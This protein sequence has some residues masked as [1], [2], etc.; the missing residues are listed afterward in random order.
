MKNTIKPSCLYQ[1]SL[2]RSLIGFA[3][4]SGLFATLGS[5]LIAQYFALSIVTSAG[6]S[7]LFLGIY[8]KLFI[9]T[10]KKVINS[11]NRNHAHLDAIL[12]EDYNQLVKPSYQAGSIHQLQQSLISL[13]EELFKKKS[14]YD[15]H[16]FLVYQ[17]IE[18]FNVPIMVLD[19]H[20]K[21]NYANNAFSEFKQTQWQT[22]RY[23]SAEQLGLTKQDAHWQFSDVITAQQWQIRHSE[24]IEQGS[25]HQLIVMIDITSALRENQLQAWQQIIRVLGHEIRNSLTPVTAMAENLA[26]KLTEPRQVQA[27]NVI[28]ERCNYLNEFVTRYGDINKP[29]ALNIV[30]IDTA[31]FLKQVSAIYPDTE[32]SCI[33]NATTFKADRTFIHQ[34]MI[35][36]IKNAIEAS[37]PPVKIALSIHQQGRVNCITVDDNGQGL[38]NPDNIFVPFY[39]TKQH[40]QGIGLSFCRNVIEQ[41]HGSL[42]LANKEKHL[43]VIA[44]I[45]LPV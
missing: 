26:V 13:S 23:S 18:H 9:R 2:E 24:F 30:E 21:L 6:F 44:T 28:S 1:S 29:L 42:S 45:L 27:L 8:F 4:L 16:V 33:A 25:C 3:L 43:G 40:G 7:L 17:L 15:Q 19:Q 31:A 35:N 22:L 39:T 14:R 11:F 10:Y 34:V 36:L 32:F 5:Y 38:A 37:T 20:N 12:N 41:H